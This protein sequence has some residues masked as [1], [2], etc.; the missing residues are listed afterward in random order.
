M[1]VVTPWEHWLACQHLA[2]YAPHTPHVDSGSIV[3]AREHDLR[4]AV[5]AIRGGR[6]RGRGRVR[7]RV[8]VRFKQPTH[9]H[10][11]CDEPNP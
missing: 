6:G 5:P 4:R 3:R 1:N 9:D 11:P 2:K 8:R 7:V 10:P